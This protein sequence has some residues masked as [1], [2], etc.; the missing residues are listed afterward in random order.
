MADLYST[1]GEVDSAIQERLADVLEMRAADARQLEM[2]KSYLSEIDFPSDARVLEIGCGTGGVTRTLAQWPGV[3][4]AVGIDPSAIFISKAREFG[5]SIPN[6]S[7]FEGDGRALPLDDQSFDVVVVHTTMCHV[8]DPGGL[9]TEAFRALRPDGWLAVFDGDYATA[10]IATGDFDPLEVCIDAFRDGFVHDQWLVRR[11]PVL[12]QSCGFDVK[13]MRSH[14]YVEAG[15]S[16]YL[17]TWIDRGADAL[18]QAGRIGADKAE[19][20]KAEAR[21]R[22]DNNNWFGHIAFASILATKPK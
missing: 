3:K 5:S 12:L 2:L 17:L 14:G 10:T 13:P 9:V 20:L 15:K 7:F 22:S 4:E 6:L 16:S 8:P 19:A 21:R 1:I 11:L 18:H